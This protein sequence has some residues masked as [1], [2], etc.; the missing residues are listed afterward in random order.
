[1]SVDGQVG[2]PPEE[3]RQP[4]VGGGGASPKA[5]GP[6]GQLELLGGQPKVN[7]G[8]RPR[9]LDA[10]VKIKVGPPILRALRKETGLGARL[11]A[12]IERLHA[13]DPLRQVDEFFHSF[14]IP[15]ATGRRRTVGIRTGESYVKQMRA[16]IREL[17]RLNM[18]IQNL[19]EFSPR[20]VRALTDHYVAQGLSASALAS[21]NTV[22]R[23]FGIWIGKP[24]LA[25]RLADLV[26]NPHAYTR[27]YTAKVSKAWS[28]KNID[29]AE[30]IEKMEAECPFAGMHLRLQLAF[31]LRPREAVML[32]PFSADQ[33]KVLFVL[34]GTKG[35]RARAVPIDTPEKRDLIE[36]AKVMASG[37]ARRLLSAKPSMRIQTAMRR[38]YYLARKIGI[39]K[40]ALGITL[41]G[42]RHHFANQVYREVTGVDSPVN[43]G[44]V[45][46]AEL[47]AK[48]ADAVA[49]L[50]GHSRR[51]IASAYIG[52]HRTLD[53]A[54]HAAMKELLGKLEGDPELLAAVAASG[55]ASWWV[56]GAAA[57]GEPVGQ[58]LTLAY[59]SQRSEGQ[60]Q[61]EADLAA[62][63][64]ALK[65]AAAAGAALR[66][67]GSAVPQA[68]LAGQEVERLEIVGW[69]RLV[70]QQAGGQETA[71]PGGSAAKP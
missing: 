34:D 16:L 12:R 46:P 61:L 54:R 24:D 37:N 39:T 31:G 23:R 38:Y 64:Q 56:I 8:G 22:Q 51:S 52:N 10:P 40:E 29:P 35:G 55:I 50:L 7:K 25:P 27:H 66:A 15:A 1:M 11:L 48:G 36:R 60:T 58:T 33:G 32:K 62:M 69:F 47:A 49:E 21:K 59:E 2:A 45:L 53:R 6:E 44:P 71:A 19:S 5:L 30:L 67:C 18:P 43:G 20:H 28:A 4:A 13:G 14:Q 3:G 63:P 26:D 42:L 70:T 57:G 17:K 65:V 9:R 41:H 68:N